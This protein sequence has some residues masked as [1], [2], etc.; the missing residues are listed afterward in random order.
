MH[1]GDLLFHL[2][3]ALD[4]DSD[5]RRFDADGRVWT[6]DRGGTNVYPLRVLKLLSQRIAYIL[7]IVVA[8]TS[9]HKPRV[10]PRV[11]PA[12]PAQIVQPGAPGESSRIIVAYEAVDLS[13]V[14]YTAADVQFMQGMISHHAQALEMTELLSSRSESED[15]KKLGLRI[16]L[17]QADEIKMMQEWLRGRGQEVPDVHAH[18]AHGATL[19]PGMLTP[20]EM[21]RLAEARGTAFDRLFLEFMIKHHEGALIMVEELLSQPGAGQDSD[22]FAFTSDINADQS[23]EINRMGA[24][25]AM[26]KELPQ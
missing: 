1:R 14:Q 21:G 7:M 15:M 8:G 18:H 25:L 12:P 3:E 6:D 23:M 17:S 20:E 11:P 10:E 24:M 4:Y 2:P 22:I 19:M 5:S 16:E 13:R 9:C 26:L